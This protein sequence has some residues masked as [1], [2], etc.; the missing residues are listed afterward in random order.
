LT[1]ED[2][3]STILEGFAEAVARKPKET[4]MSI[5][6]TGGSG[7]V[8]A[9]L[10]HML[11]EKGENVVVFDISKSGRLIDIE[12]DIKFIRGDLSVWS[13]VFNA[14]QENGV[15]EVYH[16][17]AMLTFESEANP[18]AS[19]QTNVVGTYNVLE[20]ARLFGVKKLMFTSS[21]GTFDASLVPELSDTVLQRPRDF[22][23]VGKLYCEGLG[24]MYRRKFGLDFRAVRYPS[25][26]GPGVLT[27]GHWDTAMI[28]SALQN[29]TVQC[30][31]NPDRGGPMLYYKDAAR[32]AKMLLEAPSDSIKMINYNVGGIT[33]V[34]PRDLEGAIKKHVPD[35]TISYVAPNVPPPPLREINW[36][37]SNARSEWGWS[38]IFA[39][40]QS[41][42]SDFV[43]E[44]KTNPRRHGFST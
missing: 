18:W 8:G 5:L 10:T 37:D 1:T 4:C 9:E 7:Q 6:I 12:N 26:I 32:A 28:Q 29:K 16:M 39:D 38:P 23:G 34:T 41:L 43:N 2:T 17:G 3:T 24:R 40:A 42:V 33:R 44:M 20:A 27:P 21:I 35:L 25:V 22:Y 15:T 30:S 11:V 13:G 36:N 14:I 31:V 19:F